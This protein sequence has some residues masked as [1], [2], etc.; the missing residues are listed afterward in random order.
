[1]AELI[2]LGLAGLAILVSILTA[3]KQHRIQVRMAAIEQ[4]RRDEEVAARREA[5]VTAYFDSTVK[6]T[7]KMGRNFV[8]RNQ[9]LAPAEEVSFEMVPVGDGE[10]PFLILS[11]GDLQ[12][13]MVDVGGAYGWPAEYSSG[14]AP[15]ID[16][17]VRWKDGA[18]LKKKTVRLSTFG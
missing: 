12:L 2:S 4:A 7:G 13:P 11:E 3:V 5:D 6:S 16:V 1:V 8:L 14:T 17:T 18:G 15:S 10:E 9:G